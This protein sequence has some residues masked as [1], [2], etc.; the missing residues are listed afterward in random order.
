M[1]TNKKNIGFVAGAFDLIHPGYIDMFHEAKQHCDYLIVGLHKDP[2]IERINK[3]SPVM[4]VEDR[5]KILLSICAINCVIVYKTE[6]ELYN[7]LK[8]EKIDIRF[9]G[10]DYIDSD[11]TGK[12]LDILTHFIN[13]KH[14]W[15]TTKL[16][17]M[18]A[19]NL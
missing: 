2:S 13:R 17:N 9:L 18:I 19:E 5:E 7:I 8:H 4:S 12:D 1:K 15:S 10:A 3:L 14:G 16:K 11:Y 6:K